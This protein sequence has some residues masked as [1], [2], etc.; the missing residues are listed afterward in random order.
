M[1][2][3][4]SIFMRSQTAK[5]LGGIKGLRIL[6]PL[7]KLSELRKIAI[8]LNKNMWA[9]R[10]ERSLF[11][12]LVRHAR[13]DEIEVN[14]RAFCELCGSKNSAP[15]LRF[16]ES[17]DAYECEAAA[18]ALGAMGGKEAIG[19]LLGLAKYNATEVIRLA[20]AEILKITEGNEKVRRKIDFMEMHREEHG[21]YG[22]SLMGC[23][24]IMHLV[25]NEMKYKL[26]PHV[27][28]IE[29]ANRIAYAVSEAKVALR[30]I[31][32][33]LGASGELDART[34]AEIEQVVKIR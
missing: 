14:A 8:E 24:E 25:G 2:G 17:A 32:K 19:P 27:K 7:D 22:D 9:Q 20:L 21:Y 11:W 26:M 30:A 29:R 33:R 16:V 28:D 34:K 13:D 10:F 31:S 23:V 5:E 18:K 15:L 6:E 3:G 1:V 4:N 12:R